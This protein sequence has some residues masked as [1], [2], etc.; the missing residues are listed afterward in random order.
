MMKTFFSLCFSLLRKYV[1]LLNLKI[2]FQYIIRNKNENLRIINHCIE[3]KKTNENIDDV[4]EPIL[5][6]ESN[7][8]NL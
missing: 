3:E 1:F 7:L 2:S 6:L 5:L 8:F 4:T